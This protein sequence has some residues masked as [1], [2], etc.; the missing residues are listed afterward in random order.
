MTRITCW[1]R[2]NHKWFFSGLGVPIV[3]ALAGGI[4][5][6]TLFVITRYTHGHSTHTVETTSPSPSRRE[7][8]GSTP[9]RIKQ[10]DAAQ[11]ESAAIERGLLTLDSHG[12]LRLVD[13]R[14]G[15][16]SEDA[17][18]LNYLAWHWATCPKKDH[19]DALRALKFAHR[20][21]ELKP[22]DEN[23]TDTLAAAYARNGDFV[24]AIATEQKAMDMVDEQMEKEGITQP[25]ELMPDESALRDPEANQEHYR[26]LD[27]AWKD[28]RERAEPY[29]R[30]RNEL[31][32][33]LQVYRR[34]LA[35]ISPK[36]Y[37]TSTPEQP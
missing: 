33:R 3:T 27:R 20:A 35:L 23:F 21:V 2:E 17:K 4:V 29:L 14:K 36:D 18:T 7:Q 22:N 1:I 10:L 31:D 6:V 25:G 8:E 32:A 24:D 11:Q 12:V 26:Q 30:R 15:L 13:L 28:Y 37:P 19:V 16:N 34:G 9:P 5:T